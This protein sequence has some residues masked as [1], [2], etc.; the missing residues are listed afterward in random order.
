MRALRRWDGGTDLRLARFGP[1]GKP[2]GRAAAADLRGIRAMA[3]LTR[4][5]QAGSHG[6]II[7]VRRLR[8]P[9]FAA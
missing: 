4:R 7:L 3:R 2:R 9:S 8:P 6:A 1:P 5:P